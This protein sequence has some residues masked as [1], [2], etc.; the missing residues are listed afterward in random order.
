MWKYSKGL[1]GFKLYTELLE[2]MDSNQFYSI[3][4]PNESIS[5]GACAVIINCQQEVL[6]EKR[7]DNG[8][9]GLP[10]GSV[11]P[12]ESVSEALVR[13][14]FEETGLTVEIIKLV[15]IY[16]DPREYSIM[17]Y[18]DGSIIHYVSITFYCKPVTG[19]ITCSSE[20]LDIQ[21]FNVNVIPKRMMIAHRIRLE[22]AM[23]SS[24]HPIIK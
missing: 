6:L 7:A 11:D 14:V 8:Y 12:G 13:E 9:W 20:S 15:G 1:V 4:N 22:D 10:G 3:I 23:A 17:T 18:P 16:S 19:T 24:I 2:Y 5:I 21:Y